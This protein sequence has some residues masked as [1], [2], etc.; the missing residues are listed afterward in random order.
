MYLRNASHT[1]KIYL[2]TTGL[3]LESAFPQFEMPKMHLSSNSMNY[4]NAAAASSN[5]L[6]LPKSVENQNRIQ[7][8]T[9][10]STS[11]FKVASQTKEKLCAIKS[12]DNRNK[13]ESTDATAQK[14]QVARL[15]TDKFYDLKSGENNKN[16]M[17]L[18]HFSIPSPPFFISNIN[19]KDKTEHQ[20]TLKNSKPGN[21]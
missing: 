15:T 8:N 12:V 16:T 7:E 6:A 20:A 14:P 13:V 4:S 9:Y 21:G 19:I 3:D 1:L 5:V 10:A 17:N 18:L 11:K 2:L